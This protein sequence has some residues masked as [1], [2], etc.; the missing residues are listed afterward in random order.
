MRT[1]NR[2]FTLVLLF[3]SATL[4]SASGCAIGKS[5]NPLWDPMGLT[6]WA[7]KGNG[8]DSL[9]SREAPKPPSISMN[10]SRAESFAA[11]SST[12]GAA[13][14][15]SA[16]SSNVAGN[17]SP[18]YPVT[19]HGDSGYATRQVSGSTAGGQS[20]GYY[21][22]TAST[23]GSAGGSGGST[24]GQ[25]QDGYYSPT[26]PAGNSSPSGG[27]DYSRMSSVPD[28]YRPGSTYDNPLPGATGRS[29]NYDTG[30]G[31]GGSYGGSTGGLS[32]YDTPSDPYSRAGTGGGSTGTYDY[33]NSYSAS[34]YPSASS[35]GTSYGSSNS[36]ASG[37]TTDG[38][39]RPGSTSR[40]GS[41]PWE[42]SAT[43]TQPYSSSSSGV[44]PA[45]YEQSPSSY[46]GTSNSG[47][48][49]NN[50]GYSTQPYSGGST[51]SSGTG[52]STG[53]N[54]SSG[55]GY[56]TGSSYPSTSSSGAGYDDTYGTGSKW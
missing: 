25:A 5:S 50:G 31:G 47:T 49:G 36:S 46:Y 56:S 1:T 13:D 14:D 15:R 51:Y 39:Y 53:S 6:A 19:P 29:W 37:G 17:L 41:V 22:D 28:E 3:A 11:N 10:P 18:G 16:G 2:F 4:A 12:G 40:S 35:G 30:A 26:M 33:G 38:G 23:R 54:Y 21:N 45:Q 48:G 52:N 55:A 9:A 42:A 34:P 43:E 7:R 8:N 24:Y 20:G 27:S 44:L 32:Q